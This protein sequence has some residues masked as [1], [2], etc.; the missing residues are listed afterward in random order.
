MKKILGV[1]LIIVGVITIPKIFSPNGAEFLGGF[2][3]VSFVTFLPAYFLLRN[4]KENDIV[5]EIKAEKQHTVS[6]RPITD[7]TPKI[8]YWESIK[9]LN[10]RL[11]DDIEKLTNENFSVLKDK[12][13]RER[14]N[15]L[16][17]WSE[18]SKTPIS[19]LKVYF[20]KTFIPLFSDDELLDVLKSLPEKQ[21]EEANRYGIST[22]NTCTVLMI[23][24]LNEYIEDLNNNKVSIFSVAKIGADYINDNFKELS[25]QGNGEATL[26]FCA[27]LIENDLISVDSF[28]KEHNII[29]EEFNKLFNEFFIS[30]EEIKEF[31]KSRISLYDEQYRELRKNNVYYTPLFIYN[32]FYDK[33]FTRD[34]EILKMNIPPILDTI[35]FQGYLINAVSHVNDYK[36]ELL[37][38]IK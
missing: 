33:P 16:K 36:G 4:K 37:Y 15:S 13:A 20:M 3:G 19:Q 8:T 29:E 1:I 11:A 31:I 34:P 12:D 24:W 22:Q 7:Y 10:P 6:K 25:L 27:A 35:M 32:A 28:D 5:G 26:F 9:R 14:V 21:I 18:N 38:N 30:K 17:R 23:M 2:L